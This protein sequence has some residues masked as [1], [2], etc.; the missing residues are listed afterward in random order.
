MPAGGRQAY[1]R[2]MPVSLPSTP[3]AAKAIVRGR[4]FPATREGETEAQCF[5]RGTLEELGVPAH[6][7]RAVLVALD[8]AASNI[9]NYAGATRFGLALSV[10]TQGIKLSLSDNGRPFDPTLCPEPDV[11]QQLAV[12]P[13][14]GL[15]IHIIRALSRDLSYCRIAGKN[16]FRIQ[17]AH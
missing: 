15:G 10:S 9:V 17:L 4:S 11:S 3:A 5:T 6:A 12:R 14:G 8:E 7:M 13:I 1:K 16:R 2:G